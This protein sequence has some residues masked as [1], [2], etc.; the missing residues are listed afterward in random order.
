[1]Q[2]MKRLE[3]FSRDP[4][5][6]FFPAP[7]SSRAD[8]GVKKEQPMEEVEEA[9][10]GGDADEDADPDLPPCARQRQPVQYA[11]RRLRWD[12]DDGRGGQQ[13]QPQRWW[14]HVASVDWVRGTVRL[15]DSNQ[16][17]VHQ[18]PRYCSAGGNVLPAVEPADTDTYV[19]E[20]FAFLLRGHSLFHPQCRCAP[21]FDFNDGREGSA[22]AARL[23]LDRAALLRERE[24]GR[25]TRMGRACP[26]GSSGGA[27]SVGELASELGVRSLLGGVRLRRCCGKTTTTKKR[28]RVDNNNKEEAEEGLGGLSLLRVLTELAGLRPIMDAQQPGTVAALWSPACCVPQ[29][30]RSGVDVETAARVLW[31]RPYVFSPAAHPDALERCEIRQTL[32]R[33]VQRR[34][35]RLLPADVPGDWAVFWNGYPHLEPRALIL[36]RPPP[37]HS[38]Q[39][40]EDA[41]AEEHALRA[42]VWLAQKK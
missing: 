38:T 22:R 26:A 13:Q 4:N 5:D 25:L 11:G 28:A 8:D 35:V 6:F 36:A 32:E 20:A 12:D 30:I 9:H 14:C 15:Y 2:K 1:M 23:G 39:S 40:P 41:D 21:P 3:A 34:S 16:D 7:S 24:A 37:S 18:V 42:R 31:P 17:L 29:P 27:R 19:R 10:D 33:L